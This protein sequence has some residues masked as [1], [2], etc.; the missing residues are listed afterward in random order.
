MQRIQHIATARL[1]PARLQWWG[2]NNW[3]WE[4]GGSFFDGVRMLLALSLGPKQTERWPI[5]VPVVLHSTQADC[6]RKGR[7][8]LYVGFSDAT[9]YQ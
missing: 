8:C 3:S 5:K 7:R 9:S 6:C 2:P 4:A 1:T